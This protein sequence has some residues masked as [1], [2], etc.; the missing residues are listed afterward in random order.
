M[1][2]GILDGRD[3]VVGLIQIVHHNLAVVGWY[4]VGREELDQLFGA[5]VVEMGDGDGGVRIGVTQP[6]RLLLP[7]GLHLLYTD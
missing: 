3:S 6:F 2:D 7:L 1:R 4:F 5:L